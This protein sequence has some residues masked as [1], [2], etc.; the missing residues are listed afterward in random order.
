MWGVPQG[1]GNAIGGSRRHDPR[2]LTEPHT[3]RQTGRPRKPTLLPCC[4][5]P[6]PQTPAQPWARASVRQTWGS[7]SILVRTPRPPRP[8]TTH[9]LE[10]ASLG[11]GQSQPLTRRWELETRSRV[12]AVSKAPPSRLGSVSAG[13]LTGGGFYRFGHASGE[14][15][16]ILM[17]SSYGCVKNSHCVTTI[18]VN[19]F[20]LRIVNFFLSI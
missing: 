15:W 16:S 11:C 3:A 10:P 12:K 1:T 19:N 5:A 7:H 20:K 2:L 17:R 4:G 14:W 6:P 9:S 18:N 13:R 8:Q